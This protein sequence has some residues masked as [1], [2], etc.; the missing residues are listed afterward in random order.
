MWSCCGHFIMTLKCQIQRTTRQLSAAPCTKRKVTRT[1]YVPRNNQYTNK[2]NRKPFAMVYPLYS[3]LQLR[4][5]NILV[6]WSVV[7][8]TQGCCNIL[9]YIY[10]YRSMTMTMT[11]TIITGLCS[12]IIISCYTCFIITLSL[13]ITY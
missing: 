5:N 10:I 1:L 11:M 2:D 9:V 12:Y 3:I 4:R 6:N 7:A 8:G 13:I